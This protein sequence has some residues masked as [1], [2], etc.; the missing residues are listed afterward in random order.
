M[1]MTAEKMAVY[2]SWPQKFNI[3]LFQYST[4]FIENMEWTIF[5]QTYSQR[6]IPNR[7]PEISSS[8]NLKSQNVFMP[9]H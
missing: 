6:E 8:T 4:A 3:S 5:S 1:L 9:V 2:I 7:H